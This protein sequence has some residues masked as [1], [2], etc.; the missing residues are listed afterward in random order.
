MKE[1]KII[2]KC[3]AKELLERLKEEEINGIRL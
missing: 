2:I 1:I 3:K